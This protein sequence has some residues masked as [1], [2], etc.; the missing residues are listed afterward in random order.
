MVVNKC[1]IRDIRDYEERTNNNILRLFDNISVSNLVELLMIFNKT[2]E[3]ETYAFIDKYIENENN[4]IVDAFCEIREALLGYKD[5]EENEINSMLEDDD[6]SY[7]DDV[8][9]YKLLSDYYMHLG[10]QLMSLG[11]TYSEFWS[12]ST[13]EMYQ[14]YNSIEQ[15]M[16]ND[17][18]RQMEIAHLEAGMFGS[19]VWGKLPKSPPRIN[20]NELHCDKVIHTKYGDMT[21]DAFNSI[22]ALEKLGGGI[23]G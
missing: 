20:I 12:L 23:N 18:N 1:Y 6:S 13:S 19:A 10:M 4:S 14:V 17:F 3:Q 7:F 21:V 22:K 9:D 5:D 16:I 11:L 2:S 8:S 15:K